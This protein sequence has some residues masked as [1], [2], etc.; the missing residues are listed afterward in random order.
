MVCLQN[1]LNIPFFS[2]LPVKINTYWPKLKVV[3]S[4]K[5]LLGSF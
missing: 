2:P 4:L 3:E 1:L 5:D